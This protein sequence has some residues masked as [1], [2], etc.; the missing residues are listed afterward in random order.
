MVPMALVAPCLVLFS[1]AWNVWQWGAWALI[2]LGLAIVLFISSVINAWAYI[3]EKWSNTYANIR[4]VQNST[5]EVR[6]FEA[7]KTM[8][9][10][11][12]KALLVHRRTVWRVKYIPLKDTADWILDEAPNVHAG[13]VDFVLDRSNGTLMSKRLLNEGSKQFD[14]EGIISD[15]EQYDSLLALMQSKMMCTAAYGNQSP[16]FL[17][18]WTVELLRRRFGLDGEGYQ[19]DDGMSEAMRKV[20]QAQ[21][22]TSNVEGQTSEGVRREAVGVPNVIEQALA[23]LEQ[24]SAM[25]ANAAKVYKLNS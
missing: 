10:E 25:K 24:T 17:P 23:D 9:P 2:P 20:V 21:S 19:V 8:H 13:F 4:T 5:P 15:Y 12:V 3:A 6:M 11:A 14:P 22:R 7:A 16:K 1:Q 18:P